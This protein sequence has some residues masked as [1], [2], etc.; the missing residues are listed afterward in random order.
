MSTPEPHDIII[1]DIRGQICPSCL[2]FTLKEVNSRREAL[3]D[4]STRILIK[5]DNRDA[6]STIPDAVMSMGYD[7]VVEKKNGYYEILIMLQ[8]KRNTA[9]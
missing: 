3:R 6:T 9:E 1:H 4:G 7:S 2:L 5:T 8:K